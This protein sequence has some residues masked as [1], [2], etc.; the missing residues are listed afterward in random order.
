MKL[1]AK[2]REAAVARTNSIGVYRASLGKEVD[3]HDVV[4][5]CEKAGFKQVRVVRRTERDANPQTPIEIECTLMPEAAPRR[6]S[7]H[8]LVTTNSTSTVNHQRLL[9]LR[10]RHAEAYRIAM[11]R[12]CLGT[13]RKARSRRERMFCSRASCRNGILSPGC[14]WYFGQYAL[15]DLLFSWAL[16]RVGAA[17]PAVDAA[18]RALR[19]FTENQ[20]EDW[21]RAFAHAA[22]ATSLHCAGDREGHR[23]HSMRRNSLRASWRRVI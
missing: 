5:S 6:F 13:D 15:A 12:R 22:M 18:G 10:L 17:A 7:V 21:E 16:A 1:T 3:A 4:I 9:A 8:R 20:S 2:G 14:D 11:Q 19:Y 23:R